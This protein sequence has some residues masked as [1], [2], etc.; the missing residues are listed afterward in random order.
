MVSPTAFGFNEQTAQDNHFMHQTA[1]TGGGGSVA[2]QVVREFA[3]LH[4]QLSEVHGA[5]SSTP[6]P[7]VSSLRDAARIAT[8]HCTSTNGTDWPGRRLEQVPVRLLPSAC[9]CYPGPL[10]SSPV[11]CIE[12]SAARRRGV[13]R[14]AGCMLS[15]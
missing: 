7:P 15:W 10:T 13:A 3:A 8:L 6:Q 12:H 2:E 11:Y 5:H 9:G 4:H 14:H 1:D